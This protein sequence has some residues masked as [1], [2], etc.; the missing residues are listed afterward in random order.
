[1]N[2]TIERSH[3]QRARRRTLPAGDERGF[4]LLIV[5][6]L[7][8]AL[9]LL[10][11]AA[12]RNVLTEMGI[13]SNHA[14]ST[15]ALYAAEGMTDVAYSSL[16]QTLHT[17]GAVPATIGGVSVKTVGT[18]VLSK[19]LSGKFKGFSAWTQKYR[20]VAL[21]TDPTTGAKTQVT[22]DVDNQ[23]I[24]IFQFGIFY[25]QDLEIQPGANLTV[26]QAGWIHTN[27]DLYMSTSA[28]M[29]IFSHITSAGEIRHGRKDGDPQA[30]GSGAV[31]IYEADGT[32]SH[33][34]GTGTSY[35]SGSNWADNANWPTTVTQWNGQ[36]ASSS[37]GITSLELPLPLDQNGQPYPPEH[38]ILNE[39]TQDGTMAK[40]A[41][42]IIEDGV[43]KDAA[44]NVLNT[45]SSITS[46]TTL[47]D[48]REG[49][50]ART[51]NIDVQAFQA[52]AAGQYLKSA[53]PANGGTSGLLYVSSVGTVPQ[54][55]NFSAVRLKNGATLSSPLTVATDQP[56]YIQ[57]DYN[58]NTPQPAAVL[59]DAITVLSGNWKEGG[60]TGYTS[61]TG[62]SGRAASD[63]TLNVDIMSGNSATSDKGYGG[64]FENFIR[65][66]EDWSNHTFSLTGSVVCMWTSQNT[67]GVWRQTGQYYN[68]PNRVYSF[69]SGMWGGK[70]P[71]GTPCLVMTSRGTWQ[72]QYTEIANQ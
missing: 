25:N 36:V 27:N 46:S 12:N 43:A 61:G 38:L 41:A 45:G 18:P 42:V 40:K 31:K 54:G 4:I 15:K 23:L 5:M 17:A 8:V 51:W 16:L 29:S 19:L 35:K 11:L 50:K 3:N 20:L 52:S 71:P 22:L 34:L 62:L 30:V 49:G 44:G 26:P 47:Y 66:L 59:S 57:G 6:V 10:G 28:T 56:L 37:E 2:T 63:V 48:Y 24:P 68:P 64:G 33:N 39:K 67:T 55:S 70:W 1:M 9:T 60:T 21:G 7:I 72:R 14:G 13:A 65:Y 53:S 58:K 32:S 69:N